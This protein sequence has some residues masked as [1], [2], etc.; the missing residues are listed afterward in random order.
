MIT[1]D[2]FFCLGLWM[3]ERKDHLLNG[4]LLCMLSKHADGCHR[5]S[6]LHDYTPQTQSEVSLPKD[7]GIPTGYFNQSQSRMHVICT[8]SRAQSPSYYKQIHSP[9]I[10]MMNYLFHNDFFCARVL[11]SPKDLFVQSISQREWRIL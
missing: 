8:Y 1:L 6:V 2:F 7:Q 11:L 3:V 10:M 9:R 5:D 4:A